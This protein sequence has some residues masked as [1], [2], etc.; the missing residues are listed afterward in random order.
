MT[1]GTIKISGTFAGTSRVFATASYTI[2]ATFGF[3][4]NNPNYV[5]AAQAANAVNNG[6]LRLSQGTFNQGTL[7]SHSLRA[8]TGAVFTFEGGTMNCAGQFS[9]QNAVIYTQSGG[10][11]N[12]G[13]VGNNQS[14]FGTFELFSA[15]S[16]FTM[17]GGTINIVQAST[18][19]TRRSTIKIS[20]HPQLQAARLTSEPRRR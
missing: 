2:P 14:S 17:S 18:G 8:G 5:V 3:W 16:T 1:N 15:S 4:L 20:L 11:V 12:V 9:P 7:V 19:S 10:T 13:T 6:L